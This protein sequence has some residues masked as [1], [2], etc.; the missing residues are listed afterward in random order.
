MRRIDGKI[1][2]Y[3]VDDHAIVRQ[4][5]IDTLSARD[6]II[7]AGQTGSGKEAVDNITDE[8]SMVLLDISLPDLNGFEVLNRLKAKY[9]DL[10]VLILSMH[11]EKQYAV[12]ALK[13]KASGYVSKVSVADELVAAIE[14][15]SAGGVYLSEDLY[16]NVVTGLLHNEDKTPHEQLSNRE[17]ETLLGLVS[18]SSLSEIAD[19]LDLSVKTISTYRARVLEKLGLDSNADLIKYAIKHGIITNN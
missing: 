13:S 3:I 6:D 15:I 12:R 8:L 19:N 16:H 17:M 14:K 11:D 18:G 1:H 4:G 10:P 7:I 9:P 2:I 5:L